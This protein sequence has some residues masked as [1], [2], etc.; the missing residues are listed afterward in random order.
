M[1]CTARPYD[2]ATFH[3][4]ADLYVKASDNGGAVSENGERKW[5]ITTPSDTAHADPV[6]PPRQCPP[7]SLHLLRGSKGGRQLKLR[8]SSLFPSSFHSSFQT[9]GR[10]SVGLLLAS[11]SDDG[12]G[13][14][15]HALQGVRA[16]LRPCHVQSFFLSG[17][18]VVVL[19]LGSA[20]GG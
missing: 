14:G 18:M 16:G 7:S 11:L 3:P 17:D 8:T 6:V 13:C 2:P 12:R 10:T 4:A 20:N 9:R 5:P 19:R 1:R 15:G